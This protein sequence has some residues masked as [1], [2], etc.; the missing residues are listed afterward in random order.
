MT[1][2]FTLLIKFYINA[3]TR[4]FDPT[5]NIT[6]KTT[7]SGQ[8]VASLLLVIFL[9]FANGVNLRLR[10]ASV[11]SSGPPKKSLLHLRGFPGLE[12]ISF[13]FFELTKFG[14]SANGF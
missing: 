13:V 9:D 4:K 12:L 6:K 7:V 14:F 5:I 1:N 2:F 11:N 10:A 3:N 8:K